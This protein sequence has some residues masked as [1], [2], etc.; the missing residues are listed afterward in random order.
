MDVITAQMQH[1]VTVA[2]MG[3]YFLTI[4]V[5]NSALLLYNFIIKEHVSVLAL[6]EPI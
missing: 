2:M 5:L 4:F 6:M 3:I 1:F